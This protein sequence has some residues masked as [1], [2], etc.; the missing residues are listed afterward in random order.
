[1]ECFKF[2]VAKYIKYFLHS[3]QIFYL[4]LKILSHSSS[5]L[6]SPL[7]FTYPSFKDKFLKF[8]FK[9]NIEGLTGIRYHENPPRGFL[10]ILDKL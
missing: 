3:F 4:H 5:N 7:C 8:Y 9:S 1:M 2:Y 6:K 10:E